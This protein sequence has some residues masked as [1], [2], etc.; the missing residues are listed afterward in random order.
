[1]VG[2]PRTMASA[3]RRVRAMCATSWTRTMSAPARWRGRRSRPWPRP[4]RP[5]EPRRGARPEPLATR[6]DEHRQPAEGFLELRQPVEQLEVLVGPLAEADARVDD[7]PLARDPALDGRL[8]RRPKPADDCLEDARRVAR[9]LLVVHEHEVRIG[10]GRG[11]G[12]VRD[13]GSPPRRRSRCWRRRP[14][15]RARRRLSTCRC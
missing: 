8:D 15:P 12:R 3:T 10:L 5:E 7:D 13:P 6:A 1:M 4:G 9:R 14:A 11:D 2:H